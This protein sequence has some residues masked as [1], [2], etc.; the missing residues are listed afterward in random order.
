M[1]SIMGDRGS[2][3]AD[4]EKGQKQNE[5]QPSLSEGISNAFT[6]AGEG[7]TNAFNNAGGGIFGK[8]SSIK[9]VAK[10]MEDG[11]E[12]M[13]T[14][15]EEKA[16][17]GKKVKKNPDRSRLE[18]KFHKHYQPVPREEPKDTNIVGNIT[19][20][21]PANTFLMFQTLAPLSTNDG[22]CHGPEILMTSLVLIILAGTCM[23]VCFTDTIQVWSQC[24]FY[25]TLRSHCDL[26]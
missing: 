16:G 6:K 19:K 11:V 9:D 25:Q 24:P 17:I 13:V 7:I 21:L 1:L 22:N 12:D 8:A 4:L 3:Q 15:L 10:K 20:L 18:K 2:N 5:T 14:S 26:S 23:L